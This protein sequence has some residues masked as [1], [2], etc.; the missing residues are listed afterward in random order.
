MPLLSETETSVL[1]F[2]LYIP[3]TSPLM[4]MIST[5]VVSRSGIRRAIPGSPWTPIDRIARVQ[6]GT[7]SSR[8]IVFIETD[9]GDQVPALRIPHTLDFTSGLD[10]KVSVAADGLGSQVA[11]FRDP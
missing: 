5:A 4:F 9:D 8:W 7:G 11:R 2:F 3:S 1:P 10:R 6:M